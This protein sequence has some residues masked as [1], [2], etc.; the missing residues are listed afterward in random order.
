MQVPTVLVLANPKY[1]RV[2]FVFLPPRIFNPS[3]SGLLHIPW[4]V[5]IPI[6]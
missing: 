1:Y 3:L 4:F 2:C 6:Y 5:Q